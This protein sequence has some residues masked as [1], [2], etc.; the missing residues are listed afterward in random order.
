MFDDLDLPVNAS[1]AQGGLSA[2][3]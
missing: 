1:G 2:I 3:A